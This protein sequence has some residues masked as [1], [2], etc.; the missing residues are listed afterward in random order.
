[1]AD[2]WRHKAL[3][4]LTPIEWESLCDRCGRCCLLKLE[5]EDNGDLYF[6]NIV[7]RHLQ[8][9]GCQCSHYA[10]RTRAVP[11]CLELTP[12]SLP[13]LI[14]HLPSS[15]AYK[16][17]YQGLPL[18]AWHPLISGDPASVAQAG[19]S[20]SEKVVSEDYIHPEQYPEHIIQWHE[21]DGEE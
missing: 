6:T 15:C 19:I 4:A 3:A 7:C 5:D 1:M 20:V 18:P 12:D 17:L 16:R 13:A 21:W 2:F 10:T 11:E 14:D 8:Q 9:P